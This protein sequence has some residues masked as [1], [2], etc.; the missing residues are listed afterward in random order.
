MTDFKELV[1]LMVVNF[2]KSSITFSNYKMK[3]IKSLTGELIRG[4][5]IG[6]RN[7]IGEIIIWE[8]GNMI[9]EIIVW[10]LVF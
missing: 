6:N 1:G 5:A 8:T 10:N 9:G 4:A 3:S 7:M 2:R